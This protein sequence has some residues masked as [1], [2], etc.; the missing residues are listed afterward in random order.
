MFIVACVS[1]RDQVVFCHASEQPIKPRLLSTHSG[2]EL[3]VVTCTL[4]SLLPTALPLGLH[5]SCLI[6]STFQSRPFSTFSMNLHKLIFIEYLG[7]TSKL[8]LKYDKMYVEGK[9]S[10]SSDTSLKCSSSISHVLGTSSP[11][12]PV[13]CFYGFPFLDQLS[14]PFI[15]QTGG[16]Q[17]L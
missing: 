6:K 3:T 14:P 15:T 11:L 8:F 17:S 4:V 5:F 7:V 2:S 13:C 10:L 9:Y 12:L 1:A 16:L